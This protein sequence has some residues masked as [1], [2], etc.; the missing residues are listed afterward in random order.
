M[1][2]TTGGFERQRSPHGERSGFLKKLD[3]EATRKAAG[4]DSPKHVLKGI[5]F[6]L[7]GIPSVLKGIPS[8]LKGIPSVLKGIPSV[9]KGIPSVLKGIPSELKGVPSEAKRVPFRVKGIPSMT[10]GIPF[11]AQPPDYA[12]RLGIKKTAGAVLVSQKNIDML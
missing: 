5:P 12:P 7:K 3:R 8:V 6:M 11:E 10:K 2:A 9:L 1:W 4:A